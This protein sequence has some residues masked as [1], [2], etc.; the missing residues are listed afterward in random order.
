[1]FFGS[2]ITVEL[3]PANLNVDDNE[4]RPLEKDIDQFHPKSSRTLYVGNLEN[5]ITV[6]QLRHVFQRFGDVVVKI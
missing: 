1:M 4:R 2:R 5:R 3:A 6:E